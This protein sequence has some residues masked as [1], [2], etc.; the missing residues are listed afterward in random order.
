MQIPDE[1]APFKAAQLALGVD[2][3]GSKTVAWLGQRKDAEPG[4]ECD[5][6]VLG[7]AV[8]GIGEGGPSNQRAVGFESACRQILLAIE[9]AF[10]HAGLGQECLSQACFCL[11][12]AG[13]EEERTRV[14][15]WAVE[16]GIAR[17]VHVVHDGEAMLAAADISA[18]DNIAG[19]SLISGT[20]SLAWGRTSQGRTARCGGWGHLIDDSGSGYA[21]GS[22]CLAAIARHVDCRGPSTKLTPA[23][24]ERYQLQRPAQLIEL[25]YSAK[26]KSRQIATLS[27][28]VFELAESDPIASGIIARAAEAL[29]TAVLSVQSQLN[30][31]QLQAATSWIDLAVGGSVLTNQH[32]FRAAVIDRILRGGANLRTVTV[33]SHP[34]LGALKLALSR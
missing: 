6:L 20:G 33:V 2:G 30:D 19:I 3:G 8:L 29:A 16:T 26:E 12:G 15:R 22:E 14:I 23:V 24:L 34:A 28:L 13:R 10:R 21:I 9:N 25:I 17:S 31:R 1:V 7:I 18:G 32:A 11:A 5:P 4:I 27:P